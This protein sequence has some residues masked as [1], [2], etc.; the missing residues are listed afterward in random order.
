MFN[1]PLCFEGVAVFIIFPEIEDVCVPDAV[2]KS[3]G[4]KPGGIDVVIKHFEQ[5]EVG[6]SDYGVGN[7]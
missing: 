7:M 1:R 2:N 6:V 5:H 3:R 4:R